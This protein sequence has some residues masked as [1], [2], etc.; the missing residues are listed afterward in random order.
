MLHRLV[1][2]SHCELGL[3]HSF[4]L[5]QDLVHAQY[6]SLTDGQLCFGFQQGGGLPLFL[7]PL[8]N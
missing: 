5:V 7:G 6:G 4:H 8:G 2:L 1:G 3:I